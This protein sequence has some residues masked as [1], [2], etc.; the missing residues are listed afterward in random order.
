[1]SIN[2]KISTAAVMVLLLILSL[3]L[4][5]CGPKQVLLYDDSENHFAREALER[6]NYAYIEVDTMGEFITVFPSKAWDLLVMD[7]PTA[8]DP[9]SG[10]LPLINDFITRGARAVIST[11]N[12]GTWP[13]MALWANLGYQKEGDSN[14]IPKSIYKI[15]PTEAIWE[16]PHTAPELIF[17]GADDNHP[18]NGFPGSAVGSG[19]ILAVFSTTTPATNAALIEANEGRTLLNSFLLDDGVYCGEPIDEDDDSVADSVEWWMNQIRSVVS[20]PGESIMPTWD[21]L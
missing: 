21:G 6:L 16:R 17:T 18:T 3:S 11:Q 5:G 4:S 2:K 1:M 15:N 10:A 20:Q 9:E 8:P 13:G 7:N 14:L 12:I 19:V